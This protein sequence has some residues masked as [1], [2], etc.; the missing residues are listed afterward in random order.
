MVAL[1]AT[2]EPLLPCYFDAKT[3]KT[4]GQKYVSPKT[5]IQATSNTC[6][7]QM[8]GLFRLI[9]FRIEN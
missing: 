8:S 7:D 2:T 1:Q 9:Q 4:Q 6:R 5:E 3:F